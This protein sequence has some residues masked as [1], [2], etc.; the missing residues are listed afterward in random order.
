MIVTGTTSGPLLKKVKLTV[1][2]TL[3]TFG[4]TTNSGMVRRIPKT[5]LAAVMSL[6]EATMGKM[7]LKKATTLTLRNS[8]TAAEPT[9]GDIKYISKVNLGVRLIWLLYSLKGSKGHL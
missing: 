1:A 7:T 4:T 8:S 2:L 5:R 9:K 6:T 3:V